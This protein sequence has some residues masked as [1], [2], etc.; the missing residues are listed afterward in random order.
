MNKKILYMAGGIG[1]IILGILTFFYPDLSLLLCGVVL[2]V[3][4]ITALMRWSDGRKSGTSS[5]WTL[6]AAALSLI[7]GICIFLSNSSLLFAT[8]NVILLFFLWL[9]AAGAFEILGA[10]MYRKAMTSAE[11]G[12]QAPGSKSSLIA[13]GIMI[14]VGLLAILVPMFAVV[15]AYFWVV[16]G[17]VLTGVR[18]I[19]MARS[20]GELEENT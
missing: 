7:F 19:M 3:Y 12:V 17:L 13:G 10:I 11:L 2:I 15:A 14:V 16:A 20:A 9:I 1:C 4:G 6:L 5:F 8:T 18:M